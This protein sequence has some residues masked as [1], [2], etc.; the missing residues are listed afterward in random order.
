MFMMRRRF[1]GCCSFLA[2][3]L[4]CLDLGVFCF[5]DF[6]DGEAGCLSGLMDGVVDEVFPCFGELDFCDHVGVED[7][8]FFEGVV[9]NFVTF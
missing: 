3:S 7:T 2:L 4:V 9:V 8:V 1:G 6:F 5:D